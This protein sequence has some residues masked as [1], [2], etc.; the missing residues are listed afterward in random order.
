MKFF[1]PICTF[2]ILFLINDLI[3][4]A[5][6][7]SNATSNATM[8]L[9]TPTASLT[10]NGTVGNP[11]KNNGAISV[12]TGS[13]YLIVFLVMPLTLMMFEINICH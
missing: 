9:T 2:A 13:G 1:L 7:S 3:V 8:V 11:T 10:T 12:T 6:V 4:T 5:A